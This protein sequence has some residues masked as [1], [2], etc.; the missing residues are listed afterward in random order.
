MNM[1]LL[2]TLS[3]SLQ[4]RDACEERPHA[5]IVTH[6]LQ[7]QSEHAERFVDDVGDH[8]RHLRHRHAQRH[9]PRQQRRHH[10]RRPAHELPHAAQQGGRLHGSGDDL[11]G[12]RVLRERRRKRRRARA[13]RGRR[14][15]GGF[16]RRTRR[17]APACARRRDRY[18]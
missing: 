8:R 12:G 2:I 7:R 6:A 9:R 15:F 13:L 14:V 5:T 18:V 1:Y 3:F 4:Q 11:A 16:R 17:T 10:Q